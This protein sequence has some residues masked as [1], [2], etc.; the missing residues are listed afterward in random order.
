MENIQYTTEK[1]RQDTKDQLRDIISD[2]VKKNTLN[3]KRLI[4]IEQSLRN[5]DRNANEIKKLSGQTQQALDKANEQYVFQRYLHK[6]LPVQLHLAICEALDFVLQDSTHLA[7]KLFQFEKHKI[8]ELYS[9]TKLDGNGI[10]SLK[11]MNERLQSY[12]RYM[13]EMDQGCLFFKYG[14][15]IHHDIPPE[16]YGEITAQKKAIYK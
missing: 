8:P 6:T 7:P 11:C 4:D 1:Y 3:N 9:Y 14:D 10:D 12:L 15:D 16:Q 2:V 13:H 5:V